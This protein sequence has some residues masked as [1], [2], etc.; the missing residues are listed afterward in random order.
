MYACTHVRTLPPHTERTAQRPEPPQG[1]AERG[2]GLVP[3][4]AE[5]NE[6]GALPA[7]EKRAG[8]ELA[9]A[10]K[11]GA[12]LLLLPNTAPKVDPMLEVPARVP[13]PLCNTVWTCNVPTL[14]LDT[15]STLH[16]LSL[17]LWY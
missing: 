12:L 4:A 5:P 8:P 17:S 11:D 16:A 2:E 15:E 6:K 1:K 14:A 13:S 9:G 3:P 7:A 10:A